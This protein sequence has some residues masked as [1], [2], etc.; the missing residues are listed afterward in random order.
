MDGTLDV[1]DYFSK[2]N[3]PTLSLQ[4]DGDGLRTVKMQDGGTL[5]ATGSVDGSVYMLELCEGLAVMQAN[6]KNS[7]MQMLERESKREKN[8]EARAKELRAKEKRAAELASQGDGAN[9]GE[10]WE[11]QVAKIEESFWT[12]VGGK[13][14]AGEGEAGAE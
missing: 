3:D 6:E 7:V 1:W 4:V 9:S 13:D 10:P 5:L 11:Q 14:A 2:H 12:A 8:L